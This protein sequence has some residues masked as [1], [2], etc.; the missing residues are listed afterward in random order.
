[1][2]AQGFRTDP[3]T[4]RVSEECGDAYNRRVEPAGRRVGHYCIEEV[5]GS[6]GMG[7]VYRAWD[8]ALERRVA[9]KCIKPGKEQSEERRERFRREAKAAASLDHPAI[10]RVYDLFQEDGSDYIVMELVE[11][12]SLAAEL[13]DGPMDPQR[14]VTIARHIAEGLAAAHAQGVV[15]RDLKAENVMLVGAARVKILDF[16]LA[17]RLSSEEDSLTQD[18]LVMGTSR[19]MSPEQA[20][21]D[22]VDHRSDLFSLGSLLYEMLTGRHPFQ[23]GSPL[24]TMRRVVRHR[25]PPVTDLRPELPEDLALLVESLLE[26]DPARR[27]QTAAEVAL[28]LEAMESLWTTSTTDHT[29]L[30]QLTAAARRRRRLRRWWLPAGAAVALSVALG[31]YLAASRPPPPPTLVVVPPVDIEGGAGGEVQRSAGIARVALMQAVAA[32]RGLAT[33]DP[34]TLKGIVGSPVELARAAGAA[35]ALAGSIAV[36]GPTLQLTLRRLD[37]KGKLLWAGSTTVP[38]DAA[39]TLVRAAH[40]LA[41]RAYPRQ[42]REALGAPPEA[43]AEYAELAALDDSPPPGVTRDDLLRRAAALT[44]RYPDFLEGHILEA[45]LARFL[46]ETTHEKRYLD[47]A[48]SAVERGLRM[49]PEDPRALAVAIQVAQAAGDA[50]RAGSLLQ[51]LEAVAPGSPEALNRRA[52]L[53]AREDRWEEALKLYRRAA[54]LYPSWVAF[55]RLANAESHSGHP[56]RAREAIERGLERAPGNRYLLGRLARLELLY[57]DLTRAAELYQ[58]LASTYPNAVYASNLGVAHMLAGELEQAEAAFR[59]ALELAPGDPTTLLNLADSLDLLHRREAA[60][61]FYEQALA[62]AS[63]EDPDALS[64]RAQ[65]LAHLGRGAEAVAAVQELLRRAPDDPNALLAAAVSYAVAGER[66]SAKA[67]LEKAVATGLAPRWLQL[68]WL[69]DVSS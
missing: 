4:K 47:L 53:L 42:V 60:R 8:E 23:A 30:V 24:E 5:L 52:A 25:P 66:L 38:A 34:A 61:R 65:C 18:G 2:R 21:G 69:A 67:T 26:K 55:W 48:R 44:Q 29:S 14:A 50:D 27:P 1:M 31:L 22:P 56:D 58:R 59:Q 33:P 46:Y 20:R 15:H 43:F 28:A 13:L 68:P 6:G 12:R 41:A 63:G 51:R 36:H 57:G 16:G 10:A 35:E 40:A 62:A 3:V 37:A 64:V 7:T 9:L 39:P 17:K 32:A 54:T 19:S 11:G 45:S 49:V